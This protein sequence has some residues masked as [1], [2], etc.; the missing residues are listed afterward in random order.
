MAYSVEFYRR[1]SLEVE[2]FARFL[3]EFYDYADLLFFLYVRS[4]VSKVLNVSFKQRWAQW[5]GGGGGN[6]S[7][8]FLHQ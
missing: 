1:S 4:V 7:G 8:V 5:T 2:M 3:Q 6:G